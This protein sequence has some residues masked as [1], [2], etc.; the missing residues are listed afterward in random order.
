MSIR[1]LEI[2]P[3]TAPYIR[4]DTPPDHPANG[5]RNCVFVRLT[6]DG[7]RIGWGEA[8]CGCYATQVTIAALR[9]LERS[10]L[11]GPTDDPAETIRR[12]R[13]QNRYWAMRGIGAAATSAIESAV[14]D[15]HAQLLGQPLWRILND[16]ARPVLAY[17]SAG[18]N[19]LSPDEIFRQ[20]R[21]L[22]DEGYRAYKLRAGG[23]LGDAPADRLPLDVQR[24]AAAREALGPDAKLFVDVAVPQRPQP[25]PRER[26]EA[27]LRALEPYDVGLLEE[28]AM[29]YDLE[30]YAALQRLGLIPIAG[31][32][33]FT[34]PQEFE[35]FFRAGALGVAQPDAAVV[36]G[37]VSCM[38][39]CRHAEAA[40]VP[41]CLHAWS[42]G[43]GI[44]QN[45]HVAW[46]APNAMAIEWPVSIHAPQTAPLARLTQFQDGYLMPTDRCGLGVTV[47]DE[48]ISQY[49]YQA[50]RE[51]DF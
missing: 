11:D 26:A 7:G 10:L 50:G 20:S 3:L 25:W 9:R 38:T 21:R 34:D 43:I 15:L 44:A 23:R 4:A 42:A 39:V 1:G 19:S 29:T 40:G 17:A 22:R 6:S 31:G 12:V 48:L 36:G 33:S 8:Y 27:Y 37:P 14:F 24:V 28:P 45:L 2:I 32:E 5:T 51:R 46:A 47:C 49:A 30:T 16:A 18:D 35:P 41:V 13:F